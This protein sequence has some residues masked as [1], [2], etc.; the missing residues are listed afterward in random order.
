[1]KL[2]R[3]V[4]FEKISRLDNE[5]IDELA[6]LASSVDSTWERKVHVHFILR[7]STS[8]KFEVFCVEQNLTPSSNITSWIDLVEG[9]LRNGTLPI[10][11]DKAI[12]AKRRVVNYVLDGNDL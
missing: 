12:K 7:P 10:D 4:E 1:M 9:Y 2:F 8:G 6:K 3:I 5:T 11:S